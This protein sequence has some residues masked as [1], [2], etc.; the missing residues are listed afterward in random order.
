[1]FH[2]SPRAFVQLT[3]VG[4]CCLAAA[5]QVQA[6]S[7]LATPNQRSPY[8]PLQCKVK[9]NANLHTM[10][11]RTSFES[12]IVEVNFSKSSLCDRFSTRLDS[13]AAERI[14]TQIQLFKG[15]ALQTSAQGFKRSQA[16]LNNFTL[17]KRDRA[18]AWQGRAEHGA[19][20]VVDLFG[21]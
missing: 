21:S 11:M 14:F 8:K 6:Q 7:I 12:I 3:V 2:F 18:K 1:M 5:G 20:C 19:V 17:I 9:F 4:A 15:V 13:I 10:R 16:N